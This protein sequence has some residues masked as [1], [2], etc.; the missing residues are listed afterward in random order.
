MV[1][2]LFISFLGVMLIC[3]YSYAGGHR[4]FIRSQ[5]VLEP[6]ET[7]PYVNTNHTLVTRPMILEPRGDFGIGAEVMTNLTGFYDYQT[8]GECKHQ[9]NRVNSTESHAIYMYASDSTNVSATRRSGYSF[10]ADDGTTWQNLGDV[11]SGIRSGF[12]SL[13]IIPTGSSSGA[14]VIGDHYAPG[15]QPIT[16]VSY[17]AAPGAGSFTNDPYQVGQYNFIWPGVASMGNGNIFVA[18]EDYYGS[19]AT[20]TGSGV[21]FN[22]T[23]NSYSNYHQFNGGTAQTNMRWTYATGPNGKI[24]YVLQPLSDV[25]GNFGLS[26]LYVFMS[27]NNGTSWDNGTDRKSVV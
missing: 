20:D 6:D 8:N 3:V 13:T 1:K 7:H 23:S 10:S 24:I 22:P 15:S 17:D 2:K 21:V 11:P 27:T 16:V 12:C 18:G 5:M 4:S 26:R 9:I 14:A 25:G 19:A